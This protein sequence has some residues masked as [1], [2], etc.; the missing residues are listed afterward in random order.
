MTMKLSE[1]AMLT[2]LSIGGWSGKTTDNDVTE[3]VSV[4]HKADVKEAGRYSKMLFAPRFLRPVASMSNAARTA[5]RTLTLPWEDDG[6]RILSTTGYQEYTER[7]RLMRQGHE[8]AVSEFVKAVPDAISEAK[9]RLGSMF[10]RDDYP[11][12]DAI[13]D[14]FSFEVQ[15]NPVPDAGDFRAKLGD[16]EVKAIVKDIERRCNSR[17][18]RAM[19]DIYLRIQDA[20]GKMADKLKAYSAPVEGQKGENTFRD[21]LVYNIKEIADLIPALN[22]TGDKKLDELRSQLL[23]DLADKEPEL[24]RT[25]AKLRAA[26]AAKAEKIFKK[27]SDYLA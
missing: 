9:T 17:L 3:E 22:I 19:D 27:V 16:G 11:D 4:S 25:D 6:T 23:A 14:K 5:H 15:I 20:T 24:L 12:I 21:S 18:E 8:A 10:D 1:R 13:R 26:T 7:M 2:T